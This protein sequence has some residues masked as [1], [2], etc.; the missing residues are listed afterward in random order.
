MSANRD[1]LQSEGGTMPEERFVRAT[2]LLDFDHP[3]IDRL[4]QTRGWRT[5][6][7]S[8]RIGA[9]YGFVKNEIAFGYNASDDLPASA[10]LEQGF[11]QCNTK[12]TLLMALLRA[13]GTC[14]RLHAFTIEKRV[15]KGILPAWIYA[16]IPATILHSWV[17]VAP[18]GDWIALEGV[19]LDDPYLQAVQE[20]LGAARDF[21]GYAVA[22]RDLGNPNVE[23]SG[24]DTFIQ[25]EAIAED[26]GIYDDPDTLYAEHGT[27]LK[28][29]KRWL[30]AHIVRH[31]MNRTVE[32]IRARV[33][34]RP[35]P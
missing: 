17:E 14:C 30:Y 20:T 9:A 7:E 34:R 2:R 5:L 3:S 35:S 4:I 11:G 25:R 10:V 18:E 24:M 15:Q 23:W 19:I 26:L 1:L 16:R 22:T 27:N 32:R 13:V 8:D 31:R 12:A 33:D 28:G 6:G 29:L 21:C